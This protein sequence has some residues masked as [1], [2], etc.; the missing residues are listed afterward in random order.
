[1][2]L[3]RNQ[4]SRSYSTILLS[5]LGS[6]ELTD[7]DDTVTLVSG[8]ETDYV[9]RSILCR[10]SPL[11][12]SII[13]SSCQNDVLILPYS[14]SS[15]P[16]ILALLYSGSI[17]GITKHQADQ[18]I[19]MGNLLGISIQS[20]ASEKEDNRD[21]SESDS[22]DSDNG[23]GAEKIEDEVQTNVNQLKIKTR[24][25]GGKKGTE[26]RKNRLQ[27]NLQVDEN[28]N[29]FLGRIQNEY[30]E[31]PVG[32]YMGSYDQNRNLK[33]NVQLPNS[34]LE[35]S[36][37]T[38]FNHSGNRCYSFCLKSYKNYDNLDKIDSYRILSELVDSDDS[39][40]ESDENEH[41]KKSYSCQYG[42]CK[43][44]CPCPQCHLN[45][46]QCK[47]HKIKHGSLFDEES[48]AVSIRS[49][50]N[51]CNN[52]HFFSKSYIIK[53]SGIP[54]SCEKC[55]LDLL[56]HHSYH[57]EYHEKCRFCKPSWY[58]YKAKTGEELKSLEKDEEKY[59]KTV[60]PYCDKQFIR[61]TE[62][63]R[64]IQI[65]HRGINS[66]KCDQCEKVFNSAVGKK[67]HEEMKHSA[68][69]EPV[70]CDICK[71]NFVS[72]IAR[73]AHLKY[74][75]TEVKSEECTRCDAKFKQKKNLRAHLASIHGINQM[76]ENYCERS[77]EESFK[78]DKCG[79][80][81]MY[82]K[83]FDAHV[84]NQ[85]KDRDVYECEMCKSKFS[86]KRNLVVHLKAKHG[87]Q[88]EEF[89][90]SNCGKKFNQKRYLKQHM[91]SHK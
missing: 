60:C 17:S 71:K 13:S 4:A 40:S 10:V 49:S 86:H 91:K 46:T 38:E 34:N 67:Y 36:N 58:K 51:F 7:V 47:E 44:P 37:Y 18:V 63:R 90:C 73:K 52:K 29:G 62:V 87:A 45:L 59:F 50:E 5:E 41:D 89:P 84:R 32:Q 27:A 82:K 65:K 11:L 74:F 77:D 6:Q 76:K 75:H 55:K 9:H 80:E 69:V 22:S 8:E 57:F 53:Y 35:F 83:N 20:I 43:I 14:P 61:A 28:L 70:S 66:F 2:V 85:H 15:L 56:A 12:H 16:N 81:F 31:H 26:C 39:D 25:S 19:E 54:L 1:M 24:I 79:T 48:N 21:S 3:L 68:F 88:Q 30:N 33:L 42:K 78:C 72:D 64:H 23:K